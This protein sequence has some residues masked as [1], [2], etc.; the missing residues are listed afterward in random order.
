MPAGKDEASA[1]KRNHAKAITAMR[2][3]QSEIEEPKSYEEALTC[4]EWKQWESAMKDEDNSVLENYTWDEVEAPPGRKF[5]EE[6]GS[7]R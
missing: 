6:C 1:F 5:F 7:I 4:A 3:R 2:N